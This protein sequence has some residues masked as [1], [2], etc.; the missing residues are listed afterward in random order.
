MSM[1]E[2]N[3]VSGCAGRKSRLVAPNLLLFTGLLPPQ[4]AGLQMAG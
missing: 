3:P 2:D 4:E 1:R